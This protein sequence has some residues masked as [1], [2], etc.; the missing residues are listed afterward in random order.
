M[1]SIK[2]N[3]NIRIQKYLTNGVKIFVNYDK[4][5]NK[6]FIIKLDN[7]STEL[8]KFIIEVLTEGNKNV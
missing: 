8:L 6:W 2:I 3:N 4:I 1:I 5:N 7:H